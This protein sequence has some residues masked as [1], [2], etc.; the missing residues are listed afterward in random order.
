MRNSRFSCSLGSLLVRPIYTQI[1]FE[2]VALIYFKSLMWKKTV[3]V[4]LKVFYYFSKLMFE[5]R[6]FRLRKLVK[7]V[8]NLWKSP[9]IVI[10]TLTPGNASPT[11][12]MPKESS[13][14]SV[15]F[16]P[17]RSYIFLKKDPKG[18]KRIQKDPKG[19]KRIQKDPKGSKRRIQKDRAS[20]AWTFF[21]FVLTYFRRSR[22][23]WSLP[24]RTFSEIVAQSYWSFAQRHFL[25]RWP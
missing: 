17:V 1:I 18:S 19:S 5:K 8:K 11:K 20:Q 9:I 6:H 16:F 2:K 4:F 15:D 13:K 14:S 23:K 21:P 10:I 7:I 25:Q 12:K 3:F 22:K 24:D